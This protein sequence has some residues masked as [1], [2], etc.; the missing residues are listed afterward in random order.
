VLD[1]EER[2]VHDRQREDDERVAERAQQVEPVEEA[3]AL[4]RPETGVVG[5]PGVGVEPPRLRGVD[6]EVVV[7]AAD[8]LVTERLLDDSLLDGESLG[9]AMRAERR[10]E[11][12]LPAAVVEVAYQLGDRRLRR[13]VA[14]DVLDPV[15]RIQPLVDGAVEQEVL[16]GEEVKRRPH[17]QRR[18]DVGDRLELPPG[19]APR[20]EVT[21][22]GRVPPGR[23]V[24]QR[25]EVFVR[26]V[27][28][29][30]ETQAEL[31]VVGRERVRPFGRESTH[32]HHLAPVRSSPL[33]PLRSDTC[34]LIVVR[35]VRPS[36]VLLGR[37]YRSETDRDH[38]AAAS[39]TE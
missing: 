6:P 38:A 25:L 22:V 17:A 11:A 5:E 10:V 19:I 15:G 18:F 34:P 31:V 1:G 13:I 33:H 26:P 35:N 28:V 30:C 16:F 20:V 29:V 37:R 39:V 9:V 2:G 23:R 12:D 27:D 3:D 36:R 32:R 21:Q 8:H 14:A 7:T 4:A 24:E